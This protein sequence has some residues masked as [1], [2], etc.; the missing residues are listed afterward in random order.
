M[1]WTIRQV[2]EAVAGKQGRGIDPLAR[3]AGAQ[4]IHA[5]YVPENCSWPY[6]VRVTMDT[7]TWPSV[8]KGSSGGG[9]GGTHR[10]AVPGWIHD[11]CI[12]VPGT[13]EAL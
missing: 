10:V 13:L 7:T 6:T 1:R 12:T 9:G 4:L 5:R 11:R 8:L 2:A 3:V